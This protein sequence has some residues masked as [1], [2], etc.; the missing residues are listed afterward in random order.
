[1]KNW[2]TLI[3]LLV[4]GVSSARA[5]FSGFGEVPIEINAESTYYEGGIAYADD[6]VV[7]AYRDIQ[8][9]CDHAQYDSETRDVLVEGNVRIYRS[10]Q[11]FTTDRAI[12]NLE[13]KQLSAAAV[14]GDSL[15]LRFYGQSLNT[16]GPKAYM[17]KNGVFTTSDSSK[18]DY[19]VKAKTVRIYSGDRIVFSNVRLYIGQTPVFWFPYLYQSLDKEQ[20]FSIAPGY[21]SNFGAYLL[22]A[23]T[24]PL[25]EDWDGKV[26]LDLMS[27]RGVGVGFDSSWGGVKD[28]NWGRFRSYA[29]NDLDPAQ[30]KTSLNREEIDSGRYRVS[31]QDRTYLT[32]ELSFTADINLLS[33]ARFLQDFEPGEFRRNPNPDNMLGLTLWD[34]N[35]AASLLV[36]RNL[37][38]SDFDATERLPELALDGKRAPMFRG[39]FFYENVSSAGFLRRNYADSSTNVNISDYDTFRADTFHQ[40]TLPQVYGGWL[41]VV[42]RIGMRLTYY[43][44]TGRYENELRTRTVDPMTPGALP[45]TVTES[46]RV[47]NQGGSVLRPAF[48]AGFESSFKFSRAFEDVE[49][50]ALGLDGLRHIV[51][52]YMNFSFNYSGKDPTDILQFDRLNPSTELPPIDLPQF[53]S[54]DSLDT[55]TILRLGMRN[56]LQTKRDNRTLNW[57]ELDTFVD[58][59]FDKPDFGL[60]VSD[61]NGTFSNVYNRLRFAPLPWA[62]LTIDSQLPLLD[63]GFVQVN[64]NLNLMV[65]SNVQLNIG[66]RYISDNP[67]F[68]D[69]SLLNFGGYVR[70]NDNWGVSFREL[71]E[72]EDST[73]EGQRYELHRDLSSWVASLGFVVQDNRGV[74]SYGLILTFTLKDVPGL[75][76]PLA[77]DPADVGGSGQG[78]NP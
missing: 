23:F 29:I 41:S 66:H 75:R 36:R 11:L 19:V 8:I 72:F 7:L 71:Y 39:P 30:N 40:F 69:S 15:P 31:F 14:R 51:Q 45:Y 73:L 78:K 5:Q 57:L 12:Y 64:S 22:T 25:G 26:R 63:S 60:P 68:Q 52:P 33:D 35:Y 65:S 32:E 70:I 42:P 20:A 9:Y 62:V 50:R 61:D 77:F 3:A 59:Y 48:N 38:E 54:I 56:R 37:N 16:L 43:G 49:S 21:S 53:N 67:S 13:T 18:P 46:V 55:W 1:M 17:V 58:V 4:V 27:D 47:L 24:F 34:E 10:G 44:D 74:E 6:N 76:L 2:L 28:Q